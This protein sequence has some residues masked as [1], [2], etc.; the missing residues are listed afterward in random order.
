MNERWKTKLVDEFARSVASALPEFS[1]ADVGRDPYGNGILFYRDLKE[2]KKT[3]FFAMEI[4][5][6]RSAFTFEGAWSEGQAFPGLL[7]PLVLD[8]TAGQAEGRFRIG[9]L[10]RETEALDHWWWI[11][12]ESEIDEVL[13]HGFRVLTTTLVPFLES[14]GS[15]G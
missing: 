1:R 14:V 9:M 7:P 10:M 5:P 11:R 4:S 3:I 15:K 2:K 13:G 6:K 8:E 12:K